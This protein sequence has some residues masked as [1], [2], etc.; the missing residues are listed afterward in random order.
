MASLG[1]KVSETLS[2]QTN[3][4]WRLTSIIPATWEVEIRGSQSVVSQGQS[5]KPYLKKK[6]VKKKGQGS[7]GRVLTQQVQGLEFKL[8][9]N[10]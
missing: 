10:K 1:K 4:V 9:Q 5:I 7:S 3:W 8:H 6:K 2:H